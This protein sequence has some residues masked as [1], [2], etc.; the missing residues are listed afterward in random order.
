MMENLSCKRW[1]KCRPPHGGRGLKCITYSNYSQYTMSSST[2]RT[3][4]EIQYTIDKGETTAVVLHM[5][6]VD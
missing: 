1:K 6:D 2:W 3:W 5:E 4:I